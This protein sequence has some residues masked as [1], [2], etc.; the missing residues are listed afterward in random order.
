[1][2]NS[3]RIVVPWY[4]E[5]IKPQGKTALLGF[6]NNHMFQGDCYDREIGNWEINGPWVLPSVYDTVVS[7]RCPYFSSDPCNFIV[8]CHSSLGK[9]GVLYADWGYGDHWRFAGF[10]V[11]WKVG[12]VHE[13][14]YGEDNK[15]WSGVWDDSFMHDSQVQAFARHIKAHGYSDLKEAVYKEVPKVLELNFVK[16]YFD[17]QWHALCTV[18]PR[19]Q[20]YLLLCGKKR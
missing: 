3:D 20:L 5:H 16:R 1:M 19:L 8:R 10:R 17:I 9:N 14:A 6:P 13:Y 15:L 18:K 2:G 12:C 7:L 11:G 4:K